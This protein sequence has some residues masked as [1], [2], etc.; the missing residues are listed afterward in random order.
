M[1]ANQEQEFVVRIPP[2]VDRKN[3]HIMKFRSNTPN[4]E[5]DKWSQVRMIRENNKKE[6]KGFQ[7]K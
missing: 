6:Y 5:P 4:S 3:Y 2:K 7:V 1:A